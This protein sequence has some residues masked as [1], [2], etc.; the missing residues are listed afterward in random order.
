MKRKNT[1]LHILTAMLAI[2]T[3]V[4]VHTTHEIK[5]QCEL[6]AQIEQIQYQMTHYGTLCNIEHQGAKV[7]KLIK[8]Q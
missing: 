8:E 1:R 5:K 2:L 7:K 3:L 4:M 6:V